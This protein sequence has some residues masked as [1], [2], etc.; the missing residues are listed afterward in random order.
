[1]ETLA[2]CQTDI[3]ASL[4]PLASS[5]EFYFLAAP[6]IAVLG[7]GWLLAMRLMPTRMLAVLTLGLNAVA[8]L[9]AVD[10][11]IVVLPLPVGP[12]WIR[13]ALEIAWVVW[14]GAVLLKSFA[15]RR[16]GSATPADARIAT[17]DHV[18]VGVGE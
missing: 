5:Q 4:L 13:L 6:G 15:P 17:A 3:K 14:T 1:M 18:H 12:A 10:G 16:A 11:G 8:L 2:G 7:I 9:E